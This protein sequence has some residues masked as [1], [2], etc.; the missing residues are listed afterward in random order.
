VYRL[1]YMTTEGQPTTLEEF[2]LRM[3]GKHKTRPCDVPGCSTAGGWLTAAAKW[4]CDEHLT[5]ADRMGDPS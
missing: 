3:R 5:D 1:L 2:D 4:K